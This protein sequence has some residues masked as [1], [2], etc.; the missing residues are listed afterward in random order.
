[1]RKKTFYVAPEGDSNHTGHSSDT[2]LCSIRKLTDI[3]N[4]TDSSCDIHIFLR[5]GRYELQEPIRLK[6]RGDNQITVSA[7]DN[8]TPVICGGQILEGFTESTHNGLRAWILDLPD[9]ASGKWYFQ[10]LYVNGKARKRPRLPKEGRYRM[11]YVPDTPIDTPYWEVLYNPQNTF[12]YENDD[13]DPNWAA[14]EDID[15]LVPHLWIQE[16]MPIE[17]IL[18]KRKTVVSSRWSVFKLREDHKHSYDQYFLENVFE[19]LSDPGEFYINKKS[20]K[21]IYLPLESETL[22]NCQIEVPRIN[23]LIINTGDAETE[24]YVE[25]ITF[26][27]IHFRCTGWKIP[28]TFRQDV[29]GFKHFLPKKWAASPQAAAE[30]PGTIQLNGCCNIAFKN[31]KIEM[32]GFYGIAIEEGSESIE[33]SDCEFRE[34]GAGGVKINGARAGESPKLRCRNN[35]ITGCHVHN[36]GRVFPSAVGILITHGFANTISYNE[37]HDMF[38][39]GISVGW[40]WGYAESISRDNIIEKNHIHSIGQGLISD[41]GGIYLLGCQPGTIVRNNHIHH[42]CA[43]SYGGW[44][45]YLDQGASHILVEKNLVH[46]CSSTGGLAKG[47]GNIFRHNIFALCDEGGF[48][49]MNKMNST[50]P[51]VF[52]QNNLVLVDNSIL[53]AGPNA[54]SL[55]NGLF[56]CNSNVLFD[57]SNE[58]LTVGE[59]GKDEFGNVIYHSKM[60]WKTWIEGGQDS[61]SIIA[62]PM[63]ADADNGDFNL[64]PDSPAHKLGFVAPDIIDAGPVSQRKDM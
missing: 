41:M 23:Q 53:Y 43:R 20:G 59:K 26:E 13:I 45:I 6:P 9:V 63:F 14:I 49:L 50:I 1:M 7:F 24:Q 61:N 38:Y 48:S 54:E 44:G 16:R 12:Q 29:N 25:S 5:G 58:T 64:N 42:V 62:D 35:S 4:D 21:L 55:D 37:I 2:P 34:L 40:V 17:K 47:R 33:I 32:T 3:L 39:S 27:G 51:R 22:E 28:D 52:F 56:E 60:D 15:V 11:A 18:P 57:R 31:C 30:V 8:E 19:A 10:D 46:H 36:G